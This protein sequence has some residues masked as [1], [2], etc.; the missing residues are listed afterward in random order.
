MMARRFHSYLGNNIF[1]LSTHDSSFNEKSAQDTNSSADAYL[2]LERIGDTFYGSYSYDGVN[3]TAI[4]QSV[5]NANVTGAEDLKIGLIGLCGTNYPTSPKTIVMSDYT[6]NGERIP[7]C[8]EEDLTVF[9]VRKGETVQLVAGTVLGT[10]GFDELDYTISDSSIATVDANG[11]VTGIKSGVTRLLCVNAKGET[12]TYQVEVYGLEEDTGYGPFT[13][14]NP[15][16]GKMPTVVSDYV[17]TMK[18]LTGD[19]NGQPQ[20]PGADQCSRR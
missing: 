19:V 17:L 2:R 6:M 14:V 10:A 11:M 4:S 8:V 18:T 15:Q 5:T 9:Q 7:F 1:C 13:V 12:A 16:S 20:E 3:Y